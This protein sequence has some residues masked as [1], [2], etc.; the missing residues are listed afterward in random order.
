MAGGRA[1]IGD[2]PWKHAGGF[3]SKAK[4]QTLMRSPLSRHGRIW[5]LLPDEFR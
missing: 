2:A 3:R 1:R 5:L 4:A